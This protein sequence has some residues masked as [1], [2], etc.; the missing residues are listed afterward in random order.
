MLH[1]MCYTS[2]KAAIVQPV[3]FQIKNVKLR[4]KRNARI[5]S[6]SF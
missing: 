5:S 2:S 6:W 3:D 1:N 4:V